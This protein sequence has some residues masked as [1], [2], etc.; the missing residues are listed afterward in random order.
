MVSEWGVVGLAVLGA[1]ITLDACVLHGP[2]QRCTWY[3]LLA[4]I[5]KK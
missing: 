4:G 2:P 3:Q 5:F 1:H